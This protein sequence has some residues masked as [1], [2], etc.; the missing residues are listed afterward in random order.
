MK[1]RVKLGLIGALMGLTAIFALAGCSINKTADGIKED[2]N[3][4]AR[5][6]YYANGGMFN[7]VPQK[8]EVTLWMDASEEAYPFNV[9]SDN[10]DKN[11][12]SNQQIDKGS[13]AVSR[14]QF[15]FDGWYYAIMNEETGKPAVSAKTGSMLFG[16]EVDFAEALKQGDHLHLVAK[17][18]TMEKLEIRLVS[19][20]PFTATVEQIKDNEHVKDSNGTIQ[21]ETR[22]VSSGDLIMLKNYGTRDNAV[23]LDVGSAPAQNAQGATFLAYYRDAACTQL[24]TGEDLTIYPAGGEGNQIVYAKYIEGTWSVL[25]EASDIPGK[26]FKDANVSGNFYLFNDIDMS[27]LRNTVVTPRESFAGTLEGNGHTISNLKVKASSTSVA[28]YSTKS[29]FGELRDGAVMKNVT[30]ENVSLTVETNPATVTS[31][32][33]FLFSSNVKGTVTLENVTIKGGSVSV[34]KAETAMIVNIANVAG[35]WELTNYLFGGLTTDEAFMTEYGIQ[36]TDGE[37]PAFSVTNAK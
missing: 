35:E 20:I 22:T 10:A 5:V 30:F 34:S 1:K 16:E 24:L 33:V 2:R 26:L 29:T 4:N 13:M 12:E 14:D 15:I 6:T 32:S 7:N 31:F 17:W 37:A 8:Q 27:V 3:L 36:L 28:P 18:I 9:P 25:R 19:P 21:K 11:G 23:K